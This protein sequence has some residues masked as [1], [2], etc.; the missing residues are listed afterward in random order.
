MALECDTCP[1][2]WCGWSREHGVSGC[3][4]GSSHKCLEQANPDRQTADP[5][6][7]GAGGTWGGLLADGGY[8]GSLRRR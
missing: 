5:W 3:N 2:G 1:H 8:R 7:A 6:L 4:G